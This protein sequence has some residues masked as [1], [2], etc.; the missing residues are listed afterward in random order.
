MPIDCK[1]MAMGKLAGQDVIFK[2]KF[3]W[4]LQVRPNCSGTPIDEVFV[5]VASR[6]NISFEETEINMKNGKFWIPGKAT[7][8]AITVTFYDVVGKSIADGIAGIYSWL[9]SVYS[10]HHNN[11]LQE[12]LCMG[13]ALQD[14]A[15]TLRLAMYSGCGEELEVWTIKDAWPQAINWGDLDFSSSEEATIEVTIRYANVCYSS[16]CFDFQEGCCTSCVG[17]QTRAKGARCSTEPSLELIT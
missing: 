6:P 10:F 9:A 11:S 17:T 15:A 1:K 5:K 3:R 13:S 7:W 12:S 8:E 14:Y 2:R 4:G 16:N